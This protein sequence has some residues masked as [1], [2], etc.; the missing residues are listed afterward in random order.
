[1]DDPRLQNFTIQTAWGENVTIPM[2][3]VDAKHRYGVN[4]CSS[5]G[6]QIGASIMMLL[7]VLVMNP[8]VKLMR[9][10]TAVQVAALAVN[11]IR[12][13][14]LCLFWPSQ[15]KTFYAV[16]AGDYQFVPR[17]DYAISVAANVSSLTLTILVELCLVMQAWTMMN[18]W[19]DL[20]KWL[21]AASSAILSLVTIGFRFAFCVLQSKAI[22]DTTS[23]QPIE[24]VAKTS[25]TIGAV[26]I[27]WYC[28]LFNV[29]L[30]IHLVKNRRF[31]PRMAGLSPMEALAFANGIIMFV[32]GERT[33]PPPPFFFTFAP[34]D[35][36]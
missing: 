9:T 14:L 13:V 10:Y 30:I 28:G 18:L 27:F 22:L 4:L 24:W 1:M 8:V 20:W 19:N 21:A 3:L 7:V 23:A 36:R 6:T 25:M 31:L 15:W 33:P 32:P 29:Q 2:G 5:Y 17:G 35:N 26:S 16:F 11:V 34:G 12:M